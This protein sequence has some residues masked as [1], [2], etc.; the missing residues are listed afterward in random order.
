MHGDNF[1][2]CLGKN[3]KETKNEN[4][5][6]KNER[7]AQS[8]R[9]HP[10]LS[11]WRIAKNL[12]GVSTA[13]VRQVRAS[14]PEANNLQQDA[15]PKHGG[16]LLRN[17]RVL[18]RRPAESA[19]KYIKRLPKGQGFEPRELSEQWGMSEETIRKH[20][21]DMKCIKYVEID[22][23]EWAQLVMHPETANQFDL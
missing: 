11:D 21:R 3:T 1:L 9:N 14:L 13:E 23:D 20:A 16:F 17:K 10:D 12:S 2:P 7:I 6:T 8:I 4:M 5:R 19:A 18:S 22:E 15:K